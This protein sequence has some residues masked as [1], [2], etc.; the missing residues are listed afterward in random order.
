MWQNRRNTMK[1]STRDKKLLLMLLGVILLVVSYFFVY[2]PQMDKAGGIEAENAV[3]SQ[4]LDQL[5]EMAKNKELYEQEIR[6]MNQE[7][8]QYCD[9]FPADIK[10]E[11][12]ILL[13]NTMEKKI[14][15][16]ISNVGL[17]ERELL[18]TIS[19]EAKAPEQGGS[20]NQSLMAKGAQA[21]NDQ[22]NEIEGTNE[23]VQASSVDV[24]SIEEDISQFLADVAWN[25][26]LYRNQDTLQF[27]TTYKGLKKAV[28]FL[29]TQ[30][31]RMTVDNVS[32]SF[33]SST[34]NLSGTMTVN[35]YSMTNTGNTY[36]SPDAGKVKL[37][38]KN[39]FG[40]IEKPVKEEKNEKTEKKEN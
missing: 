7:I 26:S 14:D 31:G 5:L 21:T 23:E 11:D 6:Q 32:A 4:R 1:I 33:D 10:E 29:N 40:T 16:K 24:D 36:N 28:D 30:V 2:A 15:V 18:S 27:V 20:Q 8:R 19:G 25:P 12:G 34:G 13:A 3:L 17:G 37:G 39:I 9:N 35:L 22:I 38:T